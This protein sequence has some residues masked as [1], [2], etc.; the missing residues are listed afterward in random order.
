[1]TNRAPHGAKY[2]IGCAVFS[3]DTAYLGIFI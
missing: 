3:Y 2:T 1:M